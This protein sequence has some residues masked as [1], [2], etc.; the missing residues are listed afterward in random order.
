M[1]ELTQKQW[2][3]HAVTH[4]VEG[5]EDMRWKK[6]GSLKIA[7]IVIVL[8]FFG[9]I[10]YGRLYGFQFYISYDKTFNIVPYIVRSF[11]LFGAWVIGNWSVCTLLDGEGT[12]RNICVYSAYALIPYVVQ[13]Y[14]NVILSHF[15][16]RDEYVFMQIIELIGVGWTAILLFSAIKSVH[17]YS[18]KKTVLAVVLT[19]AAMFIMLFLLVLFMSLIQQIFIFI[20]TVYTELSYRAKV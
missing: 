1:M 14:L 3:R 6:A 19:L 8:L 17:Q 2:V 18:F 7:L 12:L 9:Q 15:L 13:L 16:I 5:F 4:P 10:A 11:V 20:S